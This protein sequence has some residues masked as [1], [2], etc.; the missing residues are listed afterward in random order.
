MSIS[1]PPAAS[2]TVRLSGTPRGSGT[3]QVRGCWVQLAGC[4]VCE[5][6]PAPIRSDRED[7]AARKAGVMAAQRERIKAS[8]LDAILAPSPRQSGTASSIRSVTAASQP[9]T[10]SP[11]SYPVI[12]PQPLLWLKSDS[13]TS[14]AMSIFDGET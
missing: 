14:G 10:S 4:R 5:I 12:P 1:L 8:G 2:E 3:L 7:A 6:V 11:L 13:L 9:T